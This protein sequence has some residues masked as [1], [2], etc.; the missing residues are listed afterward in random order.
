M[1]APRIIWRWAERDFGFRFQQGKGKSAADYYQAALPAEFYHVPAA[2]RKLTKARLEDLT[3]QAKAPTAPTIVA[4][5]W[6]NYGDSDLQ[7]ISEPDGICLNWAGCLSQEEVNSRETN[8]VNRAKEFVADLA[9]RNEPAPITLDLIQRIHKE[10][11]G[12]IYPWAGKW[13]TVTLSR[14]GVTWSLPRYGWEPVFAE[15]ERD[16]LALTPFLN[17]DDRAVCEFVAKLMGEYIAL[18]P[19]REGNGRSAFILSDLVLLQNGLVPLDAFIRKRDRDRY[20]AACEA[21]RLKKNYTPLA[22][23]IVEWEAEAQQGFEA[24]FGSNL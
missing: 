7:M 3:T 12:D 1:K 2:Q 21:A 17:A 4:M 6:K 23:L 15:F 13:R 8:G 24:G 9:M 20:F 16:V 19:F 18:H 14:G 5:P 11:F 10:M 22:D